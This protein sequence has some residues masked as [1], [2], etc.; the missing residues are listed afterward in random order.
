MVFENTDPLPVGLLEYIDVVHG[1][2]SAE[3][4]QVAFQGA[5][6]AEQI[7]YKRVWIPEHHGPGSP[8]ASPIVVSAAVGSHTSKIRVG[9]AVSLLRVR[10]P[11]LS[12]VDFYQASYLCPGRLDIGLGRGDVGGPLADFAAHLRKTDDGVQKALEEF[13]E[14]ITEYARVVEPLSVGCEVWLHGSGIRSAELAAKLDVNYCHALFLNPDIDTCIW[15]LRR[16]KECASQAR[17]AVALAVAVNPDEDLT[18]RPIGKIGLKIN[19]AGPAADCAR[20]ALRA[21]ALADADELIV[22]ELSGPARHLSA[23]EDFYAAVRD[24]FPLRPGT[25]GQAP[26]TAREAR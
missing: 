12:L 18:A 25:A 17:S 13:P 6:L 21:V 26:A 9:T 15:A 11:Y 24:R 22:A 7:G 3:K 2:S 20:T 10:D 23:I 1:G 14:L 8:C 16:H 5:L 4:Q 19:C